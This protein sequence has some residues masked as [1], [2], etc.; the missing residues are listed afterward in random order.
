VRPYLK[1][2]KR[3]NNYYYQMGTVWGGEPVGGWRAKGT[4]DVGNYDP[5]TLYA[6]VKIE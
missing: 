3:K 2:K 6:C 4:G 5:S 1:E